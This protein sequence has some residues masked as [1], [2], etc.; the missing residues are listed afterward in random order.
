M[1]VTGL[2][3]QGGCTDM[4]ERNSVLVLSIRCLC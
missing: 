1:L 2:H 4:C 3:K